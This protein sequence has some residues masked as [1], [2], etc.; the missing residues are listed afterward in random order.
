MTICPI[1]RESMMS[2]PRTETR[3]NVARTRDPLNGGRPNVDV[4][5]GMYK[6]TGKYP[7]PCNKIIKLY[8][9]K[10]GYEGQRSE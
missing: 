4:Y 5:V 7:N 3:L 9:P 8:Y 10:T 2:K 1:V 6:D